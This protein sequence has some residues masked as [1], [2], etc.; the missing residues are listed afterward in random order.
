MDAFTISRCR[1]AAEIGWDMVAIIMADDEIALTFMFG[2]GRMIDRDCVGI[3]ARFYAQIM[4]LPPAVPMVMT[5]YTKYR[6]AHNIPDHEARSDDE[7]V[8]IV[9]RQFTADKP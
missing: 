4:I 1:L 7:L 6:T 9:A 2:L 5:R 8:E 3:I